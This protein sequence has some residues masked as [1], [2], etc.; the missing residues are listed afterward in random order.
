LFVVRV[1]H[2]VKFLVYASHDADDVRAGTRRM[3]PSFIVAPALI[4]IGALVERAQLDD[5][6]A[7]RDD[8]DRTAGAK[9]LH[10]PD[11]ITVL[12]LGV[13]ISATLLW[14]YFGLT[15]GEVQRMRQASGLETRAACPGRLQLPASA[16]RRGHHHL[17]RGRPH[18]GRTLRPMA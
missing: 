13:L 2:A 4:V 8:D 9:N 16:A 18:V 5:H 3:T 14:S 10:R 12:V 6:L 11:V 1:I 17:R 15:T 7:E